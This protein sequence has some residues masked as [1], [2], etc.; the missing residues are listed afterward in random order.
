MKEACKWFETCKWP[1]TEYILYK[2]WLFLFRFASYPLA[3]KYIKR[4]RVG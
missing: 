4:D 3:S 1:D 2:P